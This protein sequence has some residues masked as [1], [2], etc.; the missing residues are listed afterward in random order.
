MV[1]KGRPRTPRVVPQEPPIV[2]GP[3]EAFE[4]RLDHVRQLYQTGYRL[5]SW[6]DSRKS[7]EELSRQ[8]MSKRR[9]REVV[10][11]EHP[12]RERV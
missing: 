5:P 9:R 12:K 7:R 4:R 8:L 10:A 2:G 3:A 1:Q 11:W 6:L